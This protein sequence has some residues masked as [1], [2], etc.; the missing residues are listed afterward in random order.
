MVV[1]VRL[2]IN[3]YQTIYAQ[4]KNF[5]K[6]GGVRAEGFEMKYQGSSLEVS[7]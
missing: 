6:E 4:Y 7:G 1:F 2:T 5:S 3:K